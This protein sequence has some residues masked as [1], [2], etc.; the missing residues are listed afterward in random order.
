MKQYKLKPWKKVPE[1]PSGSDV[2]EKEEEEEKEEEKEETKRNREDISDMD[3]FGLLRCFEYEHPIVTLN[4]GTLNANVRRALA[5][6]SIPPNEATTSK[7]A[8]PGSLNPETVI[9]HLNEAVETAATVKRKLQRLVG[10]FIRLIF[11]R[12]AFEASDRQILDHL[13]PRTETDAKGSSAIKSKGKKKTKCGYDHVGFIGMLARY[14]HSGNPPGNSNIGNDVKQFISR[15]QDLGL[16]SKQVW[17]PTRNV[18]KFPAVTVTR[19][20]TSDLLEKQFKK[21]LLAAGVNI[22][23]DDNVS[24]I[25]NFIRLNKINGDRWNT[26]PFTPVEQPFILFSELDLVNIFWSNPIL[27]DWLSGNVRLKGDAKPALADV[28]GWLSTQ[29]PGWLISRLLTDIG[30]VDRQDSERK[31]RRRNGPKMFN[32]RAM[33]KEAMK[34]HLS[35]FREPGFDPRNYSD[36]GYALSGS[37]RTDGFRLQL[38]SFK[39]GELNSVRYKRLSE[40][41]LPDRI[42]STVGGVDYHLTEIRNVVKSRD[43]VTRLLGCE[44]EDINIIG[45]DLG[46]TCVVG[47]SAILPNGGPGK[48]RADEARFDVNGDVQMKESKN[49]AKPEKFYNFVVTQKALYQSIFKNRR[50]MDKEKKKPGSNNSESITDIESGLAPRA[51]EDSDFLKYL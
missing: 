29:G 30:R 6:D 42:T 12:G 50:W 3:K 51:G 36:K 8:K 33:N 7:A 48:D 9:D 41:V 39:L 28:V 35:Q 17:Q 43:D 14:L 21:G 22:A 15:A 18:M 46:Q 24:A 10:G 16:L 2:V 31:R 38:L 27:K 13:S 23:I 32:A 19:S 47:A 4:V 40:D 37:I 20:I 26:V 11:S 34:E 1:Q 25:E 44:P 5:E 45:L 49:A